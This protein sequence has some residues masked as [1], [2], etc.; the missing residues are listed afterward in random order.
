MLIIV[1]SRE[2]QLYAE[3]EAKPDTSLVSGFFYMQEWQKTW[4]GS[5]RA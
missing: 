5:S 4:P 1:G 2:Y 3:R